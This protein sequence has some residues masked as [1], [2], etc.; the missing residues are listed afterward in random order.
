M[1][2]R[3][4]C[5]AEILRLYHKHSPHCTWEDVARILESLEQDGETI[6]YPGPLMWALREGAR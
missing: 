2:D 3:N 4:E 1:K 6:A 5:R